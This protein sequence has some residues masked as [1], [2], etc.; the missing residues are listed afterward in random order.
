MDNTNSQASNKTISPPVNKLRATLRE[1]ITY[2]EKSSSAVVVQK[3]ETWVYLNSAALNLLGYTTLSELEGKSIWDSIHPSNKAMISSRI[4]SSINGV[5]P[6]PSIQKWIRKDQSIIY[7]EV[8][9]IPVA[10]EMG[11]SVALIKATTL[12]D[13]VIE[14]TF[15]NYKLITENM[16]E[17]VSLL[18]NEGKFLYVSPSYRE[19]SVNGLENEIGASAFKYVHRKDKEDVQNAFKKLLK[20][21]KPVS[22]QYRLVRRDGKPRWIESRGV[23]VE[24]E[25]E[26]H[27]V[28]VSRDITKQKKAEEKLRVSE[29]K[30]R[31]LVEHSS[32]LICMTDLDGAVLYASPSYKIIMG[33]SPE[34]IVGKDVL[35]YIHPDDYEICINELVKLRNSREPVTAVFRMLHASGEILTVEGKGMAVVEDDGAV[36]SLV[37]IS[38]DIT[39]K[40]KNEEYKKNIEKLSVVG[41]LAAGFA[42]EIRNPLTSIKGFVSLLA[43]NKN[44]SEANFHQIILNELLKLEEVVNGFTSLAKSE[45]IDVT[46]VSLENVIDNALCEIQVAADEKNVRLEKFVSQPVFLYCKCFQ[47]KQVFLNIL[48]NSLDAIKRDGGIIT[49][50]TEV[51]K[52]EVIVSIHDNGVGIEKERIRHIGTPFYTNKE[53][54]VGLGMTVSNKIISE[55]NGAI[56]IDSEKGKGTTVTIRLPGASIQHVSPRC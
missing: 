31:M 53:K 3:N 16:N 40:V 33:F 39:Q 36:N 55:H 6:G 47:I 18:D 15:N 17:I 30:H 22:V 4:Q 9:G 38:R 34:E 7:V 8:N 54:G 51:I 1:Y 24:N 11:Q 50:S 2:Y 35:A 13:K 26:S 29:Y 42:H 44:E 25:Q 23:P 5:N 41:E 46:E 20:Y 12:E 28:V 27:Y 43:K 37:F 10:N 49:I 52:E 48:K 21:K 56:E 32:D 19:Y 14:D 45:A